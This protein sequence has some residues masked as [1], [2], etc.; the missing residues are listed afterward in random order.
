MGDKEISKEDVQ[1]A[2]LASTITDEKV[3]PQKGMVARIWSAMG[4]VGHLF[5]RNSKE[6]FEKRLQHLSKEEVA[7][8]SRLKRRT[9]YWRK[10]ARNLILYSVI[11]EVLVLGI[12]IWATRA[13]D[14]LW[15]TR[16]LRVLPVFALPLLTTLLY[17]SC[18]S[19]NRMREA[20]DQKTLEK[21][22]A[23]RQSKI[24]ELKEKTNYYLTQQLIQKYDLDPAAK[25]AAAS[26]LAS[27]LGAESGLKIALQAADLLEKEQ[28]G[29]VS[30]S[31]KSNDMEVAD[32][33]GIRKR[34]N[35]SSQGDPRSSM[36]LSNLQGQGRQPDRMDMVLRDN[37]GDRDIDAWEHEREVEHHRARPNEGG[38]IARFAAMLV[39]EDPSQCY[40]LICGKCHMHNGLAKKE[41]Y[42][43]ITYYCPH[44]HA[45]N[46]SN[47]LEV[48]S[49]GVNSPGG[50]ETPS[51]AGS[52]E[53]VFSS[54]GPSL[55]PSLPEP[56]SSSEASHLARSNPNK[57][58]NEE[59]VST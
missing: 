1:L 8:H 50:S 20:K 56:N 31:G 32:S 53:E 37:T 11:G 39:G 57:A 51:Q 15:E 30:S 13:P 52:I 23:E 58:L 48:A 36:A 14:M 43:Y 7:V 41:D 2:A 40:A 24:D 49:E 27:K 4:L 26:V 34:R 54:C 59:I 25:A 44:C 29:K 55:G 3:K 5:F 47:Q 10:F 42:Q 12:A 35:P 33:S 19:F 21:L 17:S 38:W 9:A 45:L 28:T 6:D 16:A 46:K 18:S 22:R